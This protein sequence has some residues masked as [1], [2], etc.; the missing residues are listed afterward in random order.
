MNFVIWL[1]LIISYLYME[2]VYHVGCYGWT[3]ISPILPFALICIVTSLETLIICLIK[4]KKKLMF[5]IVLSGHFLLY[6]IQT[7]YYTVFRQPL[8]IK[9]AI[10]GGQD[11]LTNYYREAWMGFMNALPVILLLILPLICSAIAIRKKILRF[12]KAEAI[13]KI[14]AFFCVGVSLLLVYVTL[15]VGK[16]LETEYYEEYSEFYAPLSVAEKMGVLTMVQRDCFFEIAALFDTKST[17]TM[18]EENVEL[19]EISTPLPV[20]EPTATP[21]PEVAEATQEPLP[22]LTPTPTPAPQAFALDMDKL[23][24]ASK[25]DKQK[26]WLA[27]YIGS[28]QPTRTNEYTGMF[29]GYNLIYLTAEG[30][31]TYAIRQDLTPTLYKLVNSGFVFNNYYVPLWQTSTSDGEY[32]NCTGLIPDGQF[33]MRKSGSNSMPFNLPGFFAKEGVTS[34]AYH[35]NTMSYY[36]RHITHPNLGY[37]FKTSKLGEC[38]EAEYGD[39]IFPME[40]PGRWPS[41]D[42]EMMQGTVAEYSKL[43]RFHVYYMTISG[44]MY[45]SFSGNSMSSK[46]KDA[47][48]HLDMSENARAYYAC[49]IELDKALQ[50]L[51]EELEAAGK[52]EN[53]VICLSADHYPYGMTQEQYEELAGKDLTKD[54]DLFRNS[55][56]LWNVGIEEPIIVDKAC[57]SIDIL[58]TLLNLFGFEFD[59]RM[60]AGRD[61]FSEEEG[62]VIFNNRSFVTDT[63]CY[64]K[65]AKTITWKK[66]LTPEQQDMYLEYMKEEVK[67]RY[68]FSAYILQENYYQVI[69]ECLNSP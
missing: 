38:S 28:M 55:L 54:M 44:H 8:Q 61:I 26:E 56:I 29:E 66:E 68:S 51:L 48:K 1:A 16:Y 33:S 41:S 2:A 49:H 46:N 59:S 24:E 42:Y 67:R 35:N 30:F 58:P 27:E 18:S 6:T 12:E 34:Y 13:Q 36:D 43:D 9:A 32:V 60:Y 65:K 23:M 3:E 14:R 25:G 53:T 62:V 63:V 22:E 5:W 50:Y 31:S 10:L 64:D 37:I 69:Q 19:P 11:A 15:G 20:F 17:S 57:C 7:V 21:L 47:V 4:N 52:L 39:N 45:Y 40:N